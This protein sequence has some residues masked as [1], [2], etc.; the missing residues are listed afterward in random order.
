MLK[1]LETAG[2]LSHTLVL[3]CLSMEMFE[4]F[5]NF[6]TNS[7]TSLLLRSVVDTMN[8][9]TY[10]DICHIARFY[11]AAVSSHKFLI[12]KFQDWDREIEI[13]IVSQDCN[14]GLV[15]EV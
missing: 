4:I 8:T 11:V 10:I 3:M 2:G 13:E 9:A 12:L 15:S 5:F 1:T 6:I 7:P 14:S